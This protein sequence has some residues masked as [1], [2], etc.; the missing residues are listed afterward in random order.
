LY[1]TLF[2]G[3][4]STVKAIVMRSLILSI[5]VLSF[6][7][8]KK[9]KE[10]VSVIPDGVYKGTFVRQ[11]MTGDHTAN[12]TIQFSDS[13]FK[14]IE[15]GIAGYAGSHAYPII[16]TGSY[17]AVEEGRL[18]FLNAAVFTAEFDWTVILAGDYKVTLSGKTL[19]IG[20]DYNYGN[21]IKDIYTLTKQ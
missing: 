13:T 4:V 1:A 2:C 10:A 19:E 11:T 18:H 15:A 9:N 12:V 17:A 3:Q 16:G 6:I 14:V 5:C 21:K 7:C 8:C 20:R